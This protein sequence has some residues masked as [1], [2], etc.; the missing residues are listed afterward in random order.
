MK[1]CVIGGGST[2]TPELI[3]G[4]IDYYDEIPVKSITLMDIDEDRLNVVGAFTERMINA[5]DKKI[6]IKTTTDRIE[7]IK[8]ADFVITQIRVGGNVARH[9]DISIALKHG[10]IA[11]ETTG[12]VG[13]AKAIRTIPI[14]IDICKDIEKYAPDAWLINFTNP[15]GIVTEAVIK[16]GFKKVI[17]LCNNPVNM[18]KKTAKVLGLDEKNVYLDYVGLNHLAWV[19]GVYDNGKDITS[20]AIQEMFSVNVSKNISNVN[21]PLDVLQSLGMIPIGYLKYFYM[22]GKMMDVMNKKEKTRAQEVMEIE[23]K[24]IELYKDE[25]LDKK[26]EELDKRGGAYYSTAAVKLIRAIALNLSEIHIVNLANQGAITGISSESV[27]EIPAIINAQ[28]ATPL[29]IGEIEPEIKG[30]INVVKSYEELTVRAGVYGKY[31]DA[32]MALV[33]HPL[34]PDYQKAHDLLED[35]SKRNGF[36][37][38]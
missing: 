16:H 11:Q 38:N 37:W 33:T 25:N 28:G 15:S 14:I 2:Y 30:L 8:G 4:F 7:A 17:G 1:I 6:E 31:S 34:I 22:T 35:I 24:L 29:H 21:F 9:E 5:S 36:V 3:S 10:V 12:I 20:K 27:V 32:L 26:P 19:R 23:K 13:F 18:I